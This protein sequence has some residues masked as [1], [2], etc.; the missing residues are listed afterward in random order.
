MTVGLPEYLLVNTSVSEPPPGSAEGFVVQDAIGKRVKFKWPS[1]VRLHRATNFGPRSVLELVRLNERS[2][3]VSYFPALSA[4]Y[5]RLECSWKEFCRNTEETYRQYA[6]IAAQKDFAL[7]IKDL[8]FSS[9]LFSLRAKKYQTVDEW[10]RDRRIE[11]IGR[12]S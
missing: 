8:P 2:E 12:M 6:S 4:E 3:V 11:T 9:C 7:A 10:L 5:D 1:Y